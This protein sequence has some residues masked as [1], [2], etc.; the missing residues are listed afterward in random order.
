MVRGGENRAPLRPPPANPRTI[1]ATDRSGHPTGRKKS[2]G[3]QWKWERAWERGGLRG[4]GRQ[5][6]YVYGGAGRREV[7]G[8]HDDVRDVGARGGG[9]GGRDFGGGWRAFG[10]RERDRGVEVF[11]FVFVR[12]GVG[13]D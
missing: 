1:H 11:V 3:E 10:A 4:G 6:A 12:G 5:R 8:E 2:G 9:G 13:G 7:C